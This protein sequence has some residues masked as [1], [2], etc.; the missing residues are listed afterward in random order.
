MLP[1]P[2]WQFSMIATNVRPTATAV[3]FNVWTAAVTR[4]PQ[5]ETAAQAA[6]LVIGG[7]RAGRDLAV[8]L[9][10]VGSHASRSYFLA[11]DAP[12]SPAAIL[13]TRYGMPSS[14][15]NLLYRQDPLVFLSG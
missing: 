8:A 13:T 2:R 6:R 14:P 5:A 10:S 7:V 9:L 12:R 1:S 11:A 15:E 4:R 3:P